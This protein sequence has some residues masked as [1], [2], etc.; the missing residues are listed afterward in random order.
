M[1]FTPLPRRH[2]LKAAVTIGAAWTAPASVLFAQPVGQPTAAGTLLV[3]DARRAGIVEAF[4]DATLLTTPPF[5]SLR[6]AGVVRR[7][8]EELY[9]TDAPIRRDFLLAIDAADL[10]PFAYGHFSRLHR[11]EPTARRQFL[12]A[13]ADTRLDTVRAIVNGLRMVT[14]LL[15]YAHP[16]CRAAIGHDGTHAG[17]PPL[18]SE[19]RAH[20]LA[21]TGNL[22]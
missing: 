8:D 12:D 16:A 20:Y 6:D 3:L 9:F 13:L 19:Q 15:Y 2:F 1:D 4:A 7:L 14:G 22:P 5:P 21:L 18:Q 10:L 11:L 17:L